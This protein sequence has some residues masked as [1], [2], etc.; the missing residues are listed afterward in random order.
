MTNRKR[1]V[2][3]GG[4]GFIGS[5]LCERYINEGWNV[6]SIDNSITGTNSNLADF[7]H[8]S[9]LEMIEADVTEPIIIDGPV[10]LV[11]HFASLASPVQY[12]NLQVETLRAGSYGTFNMLDLARLKKCRYLLA[13]SSEVYGDPQVYPQPE[14][15][16][17]NV[18]SVSVY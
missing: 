17:G 14:T 18:R 4:A 3:S 8:G 12:F 9:Y 5:N 16:W 1:V 15:Y 6:V 10:D 2:I 7:I 11:L 13:S